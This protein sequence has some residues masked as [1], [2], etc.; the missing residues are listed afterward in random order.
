MRVGT[1]GRSGKTRSSPH[2][3][4][5][6]RS[7]SPSMHYTTTTS[8]SKHNDFRSAKRDLYDQEVN[9]SFSPQQY[10]SSHDDIY[11]SSSLYSTT[12]RDEVNLK[13]FR[14]I[15]VLIDFFF[16]F[17]LNNFEQVY[18]PQLHS[19]RRDESTSKY[20]RDL[21]SSSHV[22]TAETRKISK[23]YYYNKE[24][25]FHSKKNETETT[26]LPPRPEKYPTSSYVTKNYNDNYSSLNKV[27]SPIHVNIVRIIRTNFLI[28]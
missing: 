18:S 9:R 22:N 3:D 15:Y 7:E 20:V 5:K 6:Y 13:F 10:N 17:L 1:K 28:N 19:P 21:Y 26:L 23:D 14:N 24:N 11:K 25:E 12:K 4:N 27:S 8:P 16:L 2:H